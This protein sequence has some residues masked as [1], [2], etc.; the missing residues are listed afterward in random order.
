[1]PKGKQ[2]SVYLRTPHA[3][4]DEFL[5]STAKRKVIR[6]GRRGGK[7][8]GIAI[9]AIRAFTEGRRVLYA[10]PTEDQLAAFW[11]E[12]KRAFT[13]LID[14]KILTKNET[15]H[16]IELPGTKQRIRAK[17][18]Y[19]AETLRGDYADLLILD[20]YQ[21]MDETAWELVGAP[22][23]VD[24]DG[25]A[26]FIYTPPSLHDAGITKARDPRHA[27]RM[28]KKAKAAM[29]LDGEASRWAAFHFSS[30]SNPHISQDALAELSEDMTALAIRQEILAEDVEEVPGA[31]WKIKTIEDNRVTQAPDLVRIVVGVDPSG[32][33]DDIGIVACGL[34][35]DRHG[36]TIADRSQPG[37]LGPSNWATAAVQ[38]YH[39]LEADRIVAEKN[40]GGDM[41]RSTIHQIDATVPVKLV[42]SSRGK[43]VRAEPVAAAAEG[44]R[45]HHVGYLPA[46]EDEMTTWRPDD[47]W[48]PNRLDAKVF[49]L[50]EVLNIARKGTRKLRVIR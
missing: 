46:L 15:L 36:Y 13:D 29:E 42:H 35:V 10:G 27:P 19:N 39:Q 30:Y 43:A 44:G 11:W 24:N 25:D 33:G 14:A 49:A 32:G 37:H 4:Q 34:G 26:V 28:Y 50:T 41:V 23:L 2:Y 22:M 47:R 9:L 8:T 17:T 5:N 12:I 7:T 1:M 48:S 21:N 45:E 6:A 3:K 16:S 40:F 18:A 20:E 31:L 38:L